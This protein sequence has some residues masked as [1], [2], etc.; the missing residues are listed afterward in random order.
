M[1]GGLE[2][3]LQRTLRVAFPVNED[4]LAGWGGHAADEVHQVLLIR[5]GG[6]AC[7]IMHLRVDLD[8]E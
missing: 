1:P 6:I 4:D 8:I 3:F 2:L 5:V 7:Q